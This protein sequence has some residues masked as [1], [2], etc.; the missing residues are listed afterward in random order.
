MMVEVTRTAGKASLRRDV[1]VD[2]D[3]LAAEDRQSLIACVRQLDLDELQAASPMLGSG[4]DRF[5]Y[6]IRFTVEGEVRR[7][8]V[9]ESQ[10]TGELRTLLELLL[11]G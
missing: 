10:L 1:R 8:A 5:H 4:A 3:E 11:D 6:E 9:D 7:V 2:S